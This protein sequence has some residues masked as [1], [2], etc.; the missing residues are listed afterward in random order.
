MR[1][2]AEITRIFEVYRIYK[3]FSIVDAEQAVFVQRVEK[4]VEHLPGR[5]QQLIALRYLLGRKEE[6]VIKDIGISKRK[7][8]ELRRKAFH[9]L[10]AMF[11]MDAEQ[12]KEERRYEANN[13]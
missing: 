6:A 7:Y 11:S 9:N 8:D 3:D 12:N 4:V 2:K 10:A 1:T 5:G 13:D